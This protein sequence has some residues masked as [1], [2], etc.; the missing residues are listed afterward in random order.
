VANNYLKGQTPPPFDLLYWNCDSTNLPGPFA[1][2]YLRN[3]YLH[4][5][6]RLPG[7]LEMCG[8]RV[9]LA[10]VDMP[11]FILAPREDHIVPW[12]TAYQSPRLLGGDSRFLLGASGHIAGI[13]NPPAKHK[14]SY[15]TNPDLKV[16]ADAW[17]AGA[18][19]HKGSWWPAWS[20]WIGQY[21]GGEVAARSK[22]GNSRYKPVE[23]APGRY[24]KEMA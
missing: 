8:V 4:N 24:V 9:D 7:K 2:W 3:M 21:A 20:E 11:N 6:L 12:Q 18:E 23:A 22:L 13:V 5:H 17:L 1:C 10:R 15:W 16:D 14:R 19:E